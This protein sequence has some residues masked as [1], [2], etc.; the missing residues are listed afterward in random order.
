[1]Q[2]T[3]RLLSG[4]TLLGVAA[5]AT[6]IIAAGKSGLIFSPDTTTAAVGDNL[7]FDFSP[8]HDVTQGAYDS[9][10]TP[11]AGGFYSGF[12]S[13]TTKNKFIVKVNSTDPI[14]FYCSVQGHCQ[15]GMVGVI[16]PP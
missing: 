14:W 15:G 8:G 4:L 16:N 3:R 11:V 1:M 2:L 13:S 6:H 12:I 7:V 10:C 5:A 9:P